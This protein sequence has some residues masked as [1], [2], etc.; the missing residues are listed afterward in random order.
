MGSHITVLGGINMD[1]SFRCP[2]VPQPGETVS[3]RGFSQGTGG[4]GANQA[5][6]A[7]RSGA[8]AHFIGAVGRDPFGAQAIQA[9]KA[10]GVATE[11]VHEVDAPT[12]IAMIMVEEHSGQNRIAFNAGANS[13]L[14]IEQVERA[15]QV[16]SSASLL[17]CQ[18]ETPVAVTM[19]AMA[20]AKR[21]GVPVLLNPAPTQKM[22]AD[23]LSRLI[24]CV[25]ILVPNETEAMAMARLLPGAEELE[26]VRTAQYLRYLGAKNVIVTLGSRGVL[27]ETASGTR[28]ID[29]V[30]T[31][32]VDTTG[33]GDTFIGAMAAAH[34]A[35][36]SLDEAIQ[37]GQSAAAICVSRHGA[38]ASIP[39]KG[40]LPDLHAMAG[41]GRAGPIPAG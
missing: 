29:A 18:M 35:G 32:A 26:I 30:R 24:R 21:A 31:Q 15:A 2:R 19:H 33:A 38:M 6:A 11:H 40:E 37:W 36:A 34:C 10:E 5:V 20:I 25:D 39:F 8:T 4:K 1:L 3:A 27:C 12:G 28:N 14:S 9:L 23:E 13:T 7:A 17:L 16:I 22:D 41:G